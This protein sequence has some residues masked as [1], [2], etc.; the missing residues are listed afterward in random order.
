[1][2]WEAT[3]SE[4]VLSVAWPELRLPVPRVAAPSLKATVPVGVPAPG[5]VG[6]TVAVKVTDWPKT[7]GLVEEVSVV[8]MLAGLPKGEP[9]IENCTVPVRVPAPGETAFTVAVKVTDWPKTEG[10]AEE[11]TVVVELAWPTLWVRTPE[12][13]VLKLASPL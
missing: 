1:M 11:A 12:V 2:E 7:L 4:V 6:A 5:A 9:S 8:V 3:L 10:W 13:L